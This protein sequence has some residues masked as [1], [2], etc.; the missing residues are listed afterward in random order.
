MSGGPFRE[1]EPAQEIMAG[2]MEGMVRGTRFSLLHP[3]AD[4]GP[5]P[6]LREDP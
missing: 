1:D 4:Y 5:S 2:R 3:E 6:C